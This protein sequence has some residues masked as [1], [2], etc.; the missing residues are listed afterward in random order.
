MN[1]LRN[2]FVFITLSIG[3]GNLI[4][5]IP[6]RDTIDA[7]EHK[8]QVQLA[9]VVPQGDFFQGASG[10]SWTPRIGKQIATPGTVLNKL[11]TK[12]P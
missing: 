1:L 12:K 7:K 5:A 6:L 4:A 10:G 11:V 3:A 8:V 9:T 2:F